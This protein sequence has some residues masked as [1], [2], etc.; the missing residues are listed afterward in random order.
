MLR[1]TPVGANAVDYLVKGSGCAEHERSPEPGVE[2]DSTDYYLSATA[3]GEAPGR[4]MGKGLSAF[5]V[6]EGERVNE[7][8]V[9]KI[10]GELKDPETDEHL[11]RAPMSFKKF[12]ERLAAAL[13]AEPDATPD[14]QQEIADN[15][16]DSGRKAVAYYDWTFSPPKTF[17]TQYAAYLAAGR[18]QEAETMLRVQREAVSLA[19]SYAEK[20]AA[21]TRTGYHGRTVNGR[22]VGKYEKVDGFIMTVWP[23]STNRNGEPQVHTHV[24]VLNRAITSS[25]GKFRALD[26]KAFRPIKE[27]AASAYERAVEDLS[28][29]YLG[30]EWVT[31]PDGKAREIAGADLDLAKSASTRREQVEERAAELIE[32]YVDRHGY[33]PSAAALKKINQAATLETRARKS[34]EQG[35][36]AVAS[37]G[38]RNAE[39]LNAQLESVAEAAFQIKQGQHPDLQ[40]L[41]DQTDRVAIQRA[42]LQDVERQYPTWTIGNL[43]AAIDKRLLTVDGPAEK[44]PQVVE[45]MAREVLEPG[46]QFGVLTLTTPDLVEVPQQLRR[47][48]DNRS[49][50]RPH[51]DEIYAT[52]AA[53]STERRI[54][55][56]AQQLT[57]PK[58]DGVDL[59]LLRARVT[60]IKINGKDI[61]SDQVEAIMAIVSS[62]R[63]GD[64]LIGPAGAGKSTVVGVVSQVWEQEFGGR[65]L[66]L[67]TS[68]RAT[69]ILTEE[70][71]EA[72]NTTQF[73]QRFAADANGTVADFVRK[74]DLFVIDEAGMSNRDELAKIS[75]IVEA[76]GGK[77]LYTGDHQQL[78]AIGAGGMLDL[79]ATDN[80]AFTLEDI[81][82]FRE[83]DGSPNPWEGKAS[84]RLRE[85][86]RSVINEYDAR[87]R[88]LGGTVDEMQDAAMRAY[89][90]D[91]LAGMESLLIV[92]DNGQA[93]N[94][95]GLIRRDLVRLGRVQREVLAELKDGNKVSVGDV[96]Q[97]RRNDWSIK[98]DGDGLVTNRLTYTVVGRDEYGQLLVEDKN[99]VQAHLPDAYVS[100]HV[101][102][103]YASTVHAAQGRTV[104]TSHALL[105]EESQREDA[106][107]ALTRGS[108][109][110]TAYLA[111]N[112]PPDA[113]EQLLDVTPAELMAGVL[114]RSGA[115]VAAELEFRA[116]QQEGRSLAWI[117]TQWELVAKDYSTDRY[118]RVLGMLVGPE[119]AAA[120]E[121]E[122]AYP[123]LMRAVR[124]AELGGHN[125]D[126]VLAEAVAKR[127]LDGAD[128]VSAV[129]RHRVLKE[130]DGRQREQRVDARDWTTFQAP[131]EGPVGQFLHEMAVLAGD[132]QAVLAAQTAAEMPAWAQQ[133]LGTPPEQP[134]QRAEWLHRAGV[135]AAYRELHAIPEDQVSIGPAP[136]P[137]NEF[138]RALWKAAHR[139][140]GNPAD[141]L[142][143]E[144]AT[145]G[146]LREKRAQWEREKNWA[147][148]FVGE[149]LQ[150]ANKLA[151][152]YHQDA[153]LFAARLE[154]LAEGT[155]EYDQTRLEVLRAE[156]M[157]QDWA[158]R[159]RQLDEVHRARQGWYASTEAAR[160]ADQLAAEELERRGLPATLE[161]TP[162]PQQTTL[163][164][165][166]IEQEVGPVPEPDVEPA[167]RAWELDPANQPAPAAEPVEHVLW[168]QRWAD[169]LTGPGTELPDGVDRNQIPLFDAGPAA[170]SA[171]T[172]EPERDEHQEPVV[173]PEQMFLFDVQPPAAEERAETIEPEH[174][175]E[176][177]VVDQERAAAAEI[178]AETAPAPVVDE[179]E[180]ELAAEPD[181]DQLE[182]FPVEQSV[183]HRVEQQ[184]VRDHAPEPVDERDVE[185]DASP[186]T[187]RESLDERVNLSEARRQA[188]AVE[189]QRIRREAADAARQAR[190]DRTAAAEQDAAKETAERARRDRGMEPVKPETSKEANREQEKVTVPAREQDEPAIERT[191]RP[192]PQQSAERIRRHLND[193]DRGARSYQDRARHDGPGHGHGHGPS[194]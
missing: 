145:E 124:G 105:S 93:A 49:L 62:G 173:D 66:G 28:R 137:E 53:L 104:K 86:D 14:R 180:R 115:A 98:V 160:V 167:P 144:G 130:I 34:G 46:N 107:V 3:H 50:Y 16:R 4:W 183:E 185:V 187:R 157:S 24:G 170:K 78:A 91:T 176:P 10:F 38:E 12:E 153:S 149:E 11:G 141:S 48:E 33:E 7:D 2:H 116:S 82:R 32:A 31:R 25:D 18:L 81:H 47:K 179:P 161:P 29:E 39:A 43:T 95:S 94:L 68:Q 45:A 191:Q 133:Y 77:I 22:S 19:M 112:R 189:A 151:Q 74:G 92:G 23:H 76:G 192:S 184:P 71:M 37:W 152:D 40:F 126:A 178:G 113:H 132:R 125:V 90:A 165:V 9:R 85:G 171:V 175:A 60:S 182:M 42:A 65:V 129:L 21:Y 26:G 59:E 73:L 58:L 56:G 69:Q 155:P 35:P 154:T 96:I 97:A 63:A 36:A 1:I 142:D 147:P 83:A 80:G 150:Q 70:G 146:E 128:S 188:R 88:L 122:E 181:P 57:A 79:L 101:T 162:Q 75:A 143:Y 148:E 168:W 111:T 41:P 20:H 87:G 172:A 139:A 186:A 103:A 159:A 55:A 51:I 114:D 106:Y 17:S 127:A 174:Q 194:L 156:R 15:I 30:L 100:E 190:T 8:M 121:K 158:E 131:I 166:V 118:T 120:M 119:K 193:L 108:R 44:R 61:G 52:E 72:I 109:R 138:H 169:G 140:L 134:E 67:A 64:V 99:G 102:L 5:G 89:L 117:G 163:F 6:T 136:S 54:V 27:A 110:N 13:E 123:A 135:A 164:D 84:L 177:D